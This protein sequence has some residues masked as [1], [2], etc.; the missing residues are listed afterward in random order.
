LEAALRAG[1]IISA[2]NPIEGEFP[3]GDGNLSP[4][5]MGGGGGEEAQGEGKGLD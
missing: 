2:E 3:I 4:R 1:A 5:R